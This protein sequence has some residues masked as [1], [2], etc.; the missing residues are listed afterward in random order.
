M[1]RLSFRDPLSEVYIESNEIIRKID[2]KN[3][4]FYTDLFEKA[5]FKE[6]IKNNWIQDSKIKKKNANINIIHKKIENFTEITEMSSYQLYLSGLLTLD[7]AIKAL[8]NGYIIKDA[9]A[10]NVVFF[11]GK[12]I[13]LDI[14]S[15]ESWNNNKTWYAYGQFVR[16]FLIPLIINKELKIPTSSLF[17]T[18][19]DGVYPSEAKE[20]LGI[21][22]FKSFMY[23]EYVFLPSTIKS[24]RIN[25]EKKLH[26]NIEMNQK[27]LLSILNRLKKKL[28][29]LEPNSSSFWAKY[30]KN[31]DHYSNKDIEIKKKIIE[32]FFKINKGK[33]LDI[34]CNI[35]EFLFIASKNCEETHGIDIDE[36]CINHIQKNMGEKNISVANI[37]I[38]NPSPNIG[39]NNEETNGYLKKNINYFDTVI[40]FG[41][42]HHLV[43]IDRIPLAEIIL[44]LSKLTKK[45]LIFEFVSNQDQKFR[46]LASINIDL[47]KD[48]S[49]EYFEVTVNKYFKIIKIHELD[50]NS[51]R[52][53]YIL[54]KIN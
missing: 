44:L 15:F 41:L 27:I 11:K 28:L 18:N 48:F 31:R 40:F 22:I 54:E 30:T 25:K 9:S 5:F 13:F 50:H 19:R 38:S 7:I 43:T 49:K 10:W 35:G 1:K 53:V 3:E 12:P 33:V 23:L 24:A 16:N 39:W 34:G 21:K 14:G 47:Y 32:N 52:Q 2:S 46:E 29:S 45:N 8:K 26:Q 17:L 37:N 20:K 36:N 51:N 42:V 6:M 4:S